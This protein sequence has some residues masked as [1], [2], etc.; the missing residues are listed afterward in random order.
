MIASVAGRRA[1]TALR[2]DGTRLRSSRIRMIRLCTPDE[3]RLS[4]AIGRPFGSAVDRNRARRR[5]KH[6]FRDAASMRRTSVPLHGDHLVSCSRS[7]L[8]ASYSEIVSELRR[9]LDRPCTGSRTGPCRHPRRDD[10]A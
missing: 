2:T 1:F 9:L 3:P 6:A 4:F 10:G 7:I 8:D 5:L